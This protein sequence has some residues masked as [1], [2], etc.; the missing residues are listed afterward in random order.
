MLSVYEDANLTQITAGVT[1]T[2]DSDAV[3]GLNRANI[4]ATA[5]NGYEVGKSY[6]VVITTGTVGGVSVVGE[7][8]G[9]FTVG[10]STAAVDLGNA[11][12]GLGALRTLLLD[13]PT[14]AEFN[15]RTLV[16]ASYFDPAADA[17]ANVTLVA[18]V[19]TLTG[20]TA[21]TGDSFARL[22]APAGASVSAD[23]ADLPTVAEFNA[24]TLI[25]ASYFDPA[26]DTVALVTT[27]T[28]VTNDVG[29]TATAVNL[30]WD[31][32]MTES[33][34]APAVTASF[35]EALKW[36]FVLSRNKFTQTATLA[37]LRND[38]DAGDLA[39]RVVADDAT[40]YTANEWSI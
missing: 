30:I 20:H 11:T 39:T 8:V 25:A 32:A 19:T 37:T 35:R 27:T 26:A 13:I 33:T 4:V 15:A 21:Q 29:I 1:V 10:R 36:M 17:V 28:N 3:V 6:T 7:V 16:A 2:V 9:D 24:R 38:A 40:T 12:D 31:E 23:I 18:T 14:V 22:G 34:G 5:A